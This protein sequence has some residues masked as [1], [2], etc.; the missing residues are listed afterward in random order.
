MQVSSTLTVWTISDL[1]DKGPPSLVTFPGFYKLRV[2]NDTYWWVHEEFDVNEPPPLD[3]LLGIMSTRV[4]EL[5]TGTYHNG[6][7]KKDSPKSIKAI[8]LYNQIFSI[9]K[10]RLSNYNDSAFYTKGNKL[11]AQ[12]IFYITT[13]EFDI[14]KIR[15]E[16][17]S[18]YKN[19]T[20]WDVKQGSK[21]IGKAVKTFG[22]NT[23]NSLTGDQDTLTVF[24][25]GKRSF[26][27]GKTFAVGMINW[28]SYDGNEEEYN[29][30]DAYQNSNWNISPKTAQYLK[31][32]K[33]PINSA[34]TIQKWWKK[35][36][37]SPTFFPKTKIYQQALENF[38]SL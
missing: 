30:E 19:L 37:Y 18:K 31:T 2:K 10:K 24:G 21:N 9:K 38:Y 28:D 3:D 29:I 23:I 32:I 22:K 4:N 33:T 16:N 5:L 1:G 12:V 26:G 8:E 34:V 36:M 17:P 6:S 7:L 25:K 13:E 15:I 11:K 27:I 14:S 20:I 35:K